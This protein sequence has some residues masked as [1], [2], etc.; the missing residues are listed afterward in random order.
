MCHRPPRTERVFEAEFLMNAKSP[1]RTDPDGATASIDL[2]LR[3]TPSDDGTLVAP[4][5]S[6][7][8]GPIPE[9][10]LRA[11]TVTTRTA[12]TL[13]W[14]VARAVCAR[15]E[16]GGSA[17]GQAAKDRPAAA[18]QILTAANLQ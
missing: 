3:L 14:M 12:E 18:S 9:T 4:T 15:S 1:S 10:P 8:S 17:P 2:D 6:A 11:A 5:P 13:K 7:S 16:S